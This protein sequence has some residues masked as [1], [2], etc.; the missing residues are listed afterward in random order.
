MR[1]ILLYGSAGGVLIALLKYLEYQH[2]VR[3]Y[4]TEVYGGLVAVIFSALGIY[5]GTRMARSKQVVVVKE[6]RV[7]EGAPFELDAGKLKEL[8]ITQR[9]HEILGLIAEGLSNR[10]IGER[11]FVSENTVKTHSSRLFVKLGVNRRVQAVQRARE[12]GLIP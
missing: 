7:S 10:E 2:F 8:G 6:V 4:P 12:L 3:A 5:F 11:L 9:E 1:R